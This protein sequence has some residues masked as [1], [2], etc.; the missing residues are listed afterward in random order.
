MSFNRAKRTFLCIVLSFAMILEFAGFQPVYADAAEAAADKANAAGTPTPVPTATVTPTA[1]PKPTSTPG[2]TTATG[3]ANKEDKSTDKR[4]ISKLIGEQKFTVSNSKISMATYEKGNG[5]MIKGSGAD[6]AESTFSFK[7]TFDFGIQEVSHIVVDGLAA[8]KKKVFLQFYLDDDKEFFVSIKLNCQ[9][10]DDYW[11]FDKNICK[12]LKDKK[13]KG[14]HKISFKVVTEDKS[15]VKFLLRY[16][17]FMKSDVPTISFDIDES[18]G[19]IAEMNSDSSHNTECYGNMSLDIPSDYKSEY[20]DKKYESGK[21]ELDYI[22][23]RG[24]S[25]WYADKKPYKFKLTKSTDFFGMGKNKHWVLLAN[26]YDATMLRN[27]FTY[28]LGAELGMKYTPQ[29]VFVDV[30]MNDVYLGSYYLCEQVRVGSSR[31]NIDDLEADESSK[32]ATSGSVITGGYLLGMSPY[33]EN[34]NQSQWISTERGNTFVIQSPSFD[35]YFN[36]AQYNYISKYMQDTE[37]A[38]YGENFKD[39]DGKSY[40]DYMDIDAAI[41]YYWVQEISSN[42][43]A[44][45][46][47]STYLFKERDGKLFWGPLWDFDYVAWGN[48]DT[49]TTGFSKNNS[50]WFE[51]LLQDE[52]FVKKMIERWPAVKNKLLEACKDGGKLDKY[53]EELAGSQ[54]A[55]YNINE[56]YS[57]TWMMDDGFVVVDGVQV[58]GGISSGTS[59]DSYDSEVARLKKWISDRVTWI[60]NNINELVPVTYKV[61]FMSDGKVY[62]EDTVTKNS[63]RGVALPEEPVKDGYKFMGWYSKMTVNG[64]EYENIISDGYYISEDTVFY[65]KWVENS[66]II[67]ATKISF[68]AEEYYRY[69][70]DYFALPVYSIP[71]GSVIEDVTYASSNENVASVSV[72]YNGDVIISTSAVGD[73]TIT[74][75]TADGLTAT[76]VLHVIDYSEASGI[77]DFDI[78]EAE[79]TLNAGDYSRIVPKTV[80][81]K[82]PYADFTY[83][84]TDDNLAEV[85]EAGYIYA[86]K[87]GTVYVAVVCNNM[88]TMKFCKV[89]IVDP[90]VKTGTKFTVNGLKYEITA[91]G[92]A[93]TVK[94]TGMENKSSKNVTIPSTV[95]YK[96]SKFK[97]TVIGKS[98]FAGSSKLKKVV[99][100]SNVT[101]IEAKAFYNCKELKLLDI[102]SKKLKKVGSN[103]IA[104]VS[105]KFELRAPDGKYDKYIKLFI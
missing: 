93:G 48:V 35:D 78:G 85:N 7:D 3:T 90:D 82:C 2:V 19:S 99:V 89:T 21:Y 20:S 29:C 53:A 62:K 18:E 37:N 98:A 69:I 33:T 4:E 76:C 23:G 54:K 72:N 25:T 74:A 36:E 39:A 100:G 44:Y 40:G 83:A 67:K 42:G 75:T 92:T 26:Y 94:C 15:D 59:S 41:D 45:G 28:W 77:K 68:G 96:G 52:T 101:T 43:D 8:K 46:S 104:K 64:K 38:I 11:N 79:L 97:V 70:Y 16:I 87:A 71:F 6:I 30:V 81:E 24:N 1:T 86:K 34:D 51:R 47:S 22:R 50:T 61:T 55:N 17:F 10:R 63:Y 31:V 105:D 58:N 95:T 57:D 66:K 14:S 49:N 32:N 12:S 80:P 5:V 13:I 102:R 56:M 91:I 60:D 27:K 9:K 65:A 73:V 84:V 88:E 103:A